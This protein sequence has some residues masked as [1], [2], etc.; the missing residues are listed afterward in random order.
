MIE[1]VVVERIVLDSFGK[2]IVRRYV[3]GFCDFEFKVDMDVISNDSLC[4]NLFVYVED[5]VVIKNFLN[6]NFV[7]V[8]VEELI[9]VRVEQLFFVGN[10][11][12]VVDE[13]IISGFYFNRI[14]VNVFVSIEL[15]YFDIFL[16]GYVVF[17]DLC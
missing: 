5:I 16:D 10:R 12:V 17:F 1:F 14:V 9:D 2:C 6:I 15:N 11:N 3:G 4:V 13:V 7:V 8:C